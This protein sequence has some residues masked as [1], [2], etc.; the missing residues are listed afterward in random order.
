MR[1]AGTVFAPP[2]FNQ[3]DGAYLTNANQN[4]M[5]IAQIETRLGVEN[6][7]D[8]AA[9]DGVGMFYT[10]LISTASSSEFIKKTHDR[11]MDA[12]E[13]ALCRP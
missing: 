11:L 3:D 13:N 4:T 7:K 6:S 9:V 2:V 5:L 12:P 1:G 8:I 10:C